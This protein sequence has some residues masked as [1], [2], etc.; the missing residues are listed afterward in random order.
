VLSYLIGEPKE[1][2]ACLN[3]L[4]IRTQNIFSD[5][6]VWRGVERLTEAL[7][8][9]GTIPG[10]DAKVIILAGFDERMNASR[11]A[12]ERKSPGDELPELGPSAQ[13]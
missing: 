9:G 13:E 1:L 4:R 5:P 3:W 11:A 8:Q 2:E 10:K 6:N 12:R 7:I